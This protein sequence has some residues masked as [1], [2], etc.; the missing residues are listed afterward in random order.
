MRNNSSTCTIFRGL[1]IPRKSYL[2]SSNFNRSMDL[3]FNERYHRIRRLEQ[4]FFAGRPLL[5]KIPISELRGGRSLLWFYLDFSRTG[6]VQEKDKTI[7][8]TRT[9][10]DPVHPFHWK[11][12]V[13]LQQT[14]MFMSPFKSVFYPTLMINCIRQMIGRIT[15]IFINIDRKWWRKMKLRYKCCGRT[16]NSNRL[17]HHVPGKYSKTFGGAYIRKK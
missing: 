2:S 10:L 12:L 6:A 14:A 16:L 7:M 17:W 4:F 3:W 13:S 5:W 9:I 11:T 15:I 1:S 8:T